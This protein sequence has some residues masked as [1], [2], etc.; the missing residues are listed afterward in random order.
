MKRDK[1]LMVDDKTICFVVPS[2]W[3]NYRYT[4]IDK[5]R[6]CTALFRAEIRDMELLETYTILRVKTLI[7]GRRGRDWL[8]MIHAEQ[9]ENGEM[10]NTYWI[11]NVLTDRLKAHPFH[12]VEPTKFI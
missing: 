7:P 11:A 1:P 9:N 4:Q 6:A 8:I 12:F 3:L 10:F 5:Y 2:E